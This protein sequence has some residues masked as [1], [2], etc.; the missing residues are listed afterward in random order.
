MK[1]IFDEN[2]VKKNGKFVILFIVL[3]IVLIIIQFLKAPDEFFDSELKDEDIDFSKLVINE[4][5]NSNTGSYVDDNGNSYD[6]IEIYNGTEKDVNLTNYGLSDTDSGIK[7][8]FP[9]NTIIKS[10]DYLVVFLSGN[11]DSGL[12]TNFALSKEKNEYVTFTSPRGKVIDSIKV[13]ILDKNMVM[14]RDTDGKWI[15]TSSI[16]PGYSNNQEGREQYLN[17]LISED[18]SIIITEILPKNKGLIK[19]DN[20]YD[21][22]VEIQNTTNHDIN[23]GSYSIS[24]DINV[25]FKWKLPDIK[26]KPNQVYL[27]KQSDMNKDGETNFHLDNKEGYVILSNKQHIVQKL[28]YQN[29]INGFAYLKLSDSYLAS[30]NIS[31]GYENTD[32]GIKK[33][34]EEKRINNEDLIINEVMNYN[35]KYMMNNDTYYDWIELYNNSKK[36]INLSDY[37]ITN[38]E[39]TLDK[40]RLPDVELKAGE[41]YILLASGDTNLTGNY[42]HI[43]FKISSEEGIYLVKDNKIVDSMFVANVPLG[44]SYGKGIKTGLY[45]YSNPTPRGANEGES[46][47]SISFEP[48]F[49]TKPGVYDNDKNL[50]IK[51]DGL[52]DIY[53]TLDG[54]TPN[55]DSKKYKDK[56][57]I[58]K[59]TVIKAVAYEKDK[60]VSSVVTGTYFLGEKHTLPV[61]SISL[62]DSKFNDLHKDLGASLTVN[63]HAELYEKNSSFSVDCGMKLF[64][65]QTRYIP[66]KSFALKFSSK[67]GVSKLRYK[68]FDNRDVEK[69]DT[70][71]VRSGSQDSEGSMFRDELATSLMNDYG[72]VDVQ[73][74]KP[75]ILY[76]NGNYWGVYFL[77]E[78]VDEKFIGNHYENIDNSKTNIVRIDNVITTG[79]SKAYNELLNYINSHDMSKDS[80]YEW[81]SEHL[82]IDNYIDYL[83]GEL[84]TT[85]NDIVN[86]RY[87]N[88]PDIDNGKIKM[89]FYDFDYAFYNVD[90]D[91]LSWLT[92]PKGMGDHHFD[93]TIIRGLM[94]NKKF[95][96]KF[97]EKL[98][99]NMKNVWSDENV[100]KRYDELYNLIEPEMERNQKRWNSSY[101]TWQKECDMLKNYIKNRR[102]NLKSNVKSYFGLS[103]EEMKKYFE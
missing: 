71:V 96:N 94:K 85:N 8:K 43:N 60:Q 41:Y 53:Y 69:Y 15:T 11:K 65:G 92:N 1:K 36:D 76:I 38:D 98:S 52:G 80:S 13:E 33:F 86:T 77:R 73:G 103:D 74:Y 56:I 45:Y 64:G 68:V 66:K 37:Y 54:S 100:L 35:D 87:F 70:I 24:N 84:Y 7:W 27:I 12:H 83:I 19:L 72:T 18:D 78:K 46:I 91:Y 23:I 101:S 61:M 14:A 90:R 95:K 51:L 59:T 4:I 21:E 17:N 62:D 97:L 63:A 88:N 30:I 89:I 5:M 42:T 32:N 79:N 81:V 34:N 22:Y 10:K 49:S 99:Y 58:D 29:L 28:E 50:D 40:N 31:P 26:L 20:T 3:A 44:Y 48:I 82:D 57:H 93:N 67:Y 25:P 47:V 9:S 16:T 102:K 2:I 75:V 39:D 55:K 6:W